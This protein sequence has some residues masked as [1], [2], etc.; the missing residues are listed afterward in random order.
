MRI[1]E[2][3]WKEYEKD[4]P[5]RRCKMNDGKSQT[6]NTALRARRVVKHGICSQCKLANISYFTL[7]TNLAYS[8]QFNLLLDFYFFF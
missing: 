7:Q 1:Q 3:C 2:H 6:T 5:E 8:I 4:S